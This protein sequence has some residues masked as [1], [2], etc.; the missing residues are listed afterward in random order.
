MKGFLKATA[1]LLIPLIFLLIG[2]VSP[3]SAAGEFWSTPVKI[4]QSLNKAL[5]PVEV[6]DNKGYVHSVWMEVGPNW[7][8]LPSPGLFYS[9]WNGG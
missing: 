7:D 6:A 2:M 1:L 3:A 5:M 8:N 9:F 4:S